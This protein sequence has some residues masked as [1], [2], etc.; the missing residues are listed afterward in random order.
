MT[1]G[2][3]ERV[4]EMMPLKACRLAGAQKHW[5]PP[6]PWQHS[7]RPIFLGLG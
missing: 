2:D 7:S 6:P 1:A 3:G 5:F 4:L